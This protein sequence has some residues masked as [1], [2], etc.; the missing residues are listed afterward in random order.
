MS[1]SMQAKIKERIDYE[2]QCGV[3][4]T[5]HQGCLVQS[6]GTSY[7]AWLVD[8]YWDTL[9][10]S[11]AFYNLRKGVYNNKDLLGANRLCE[12]LHSNPTL[13]EIEVTKRM[14]KGKELFKE[15]LPDLPLGPQ[16]A[17]AYGKRLPVA[18]LGVI[19]R[20]VSPVESRIWP[21]SQS[22]APIVSPKEI[23][24]KTTPSGMDSVPDY[25]KIE[26]LS[27]VVDSDEGKLVAKT[28]EFFRR[29]EL[30]QKRAVV[31]SDEQQSVMFSHLFNDCVLI[32]D[33][34]PGTGKTSTM[35]QRLKLLISED[36]YTDNDYSQDDFTDGTD[37]QKLRTIWNSFLK[38][39]PDNQK[40]AFFSPTI[41]LQN[42]L[43]KNL[44]AEG[45]PDPVNSIK[46]WNE[47]DAPG[48]SYAFQIARDEYHFVNTIMKVGGKLIRKPVNNFFKSNPKTVYATFEELLLANLTAKYKEKFQLVAQKINGLTNEK[49]K[50][51]SSVLPKTDSIE[52]YFRTIERLSRAQAAETLEEIWHD[53][54]GV[55][56]ESS[57]LL[58]DFAKKNA[59]EIVQHFKSLKGKDDISLFYKWSMLIYILDKTQGAV[60]RNASRRTKRREKE[61]GIDSM[62]SA[63]T[64][65]GLFKFAMG[66][67][68]PEKNLRGFAYSD[69]LVDVNFV[70]QFS[71]VKSILSTKQEEA[72]VRYNEI[73]P[74]YQK[75][76][77]EHKEIQAL[78]NGGGAYSRSEYDRIELEY[79]EIQKKYQDAKEE[80][81]RIERW[82]ALDYSTADEWIDEYENFTFD[83]VRAIAE[84]YVRKPVKGMESALKNFDLYNKAKELFAD[85]RDLQSELDKVDC[86]NDL[87]DFLAYDLKSVYEQEFRGTQGFNSISDGIAIL[88]PQEH[89]FLIYAGNKI[90][91]KLYRINEERFNREYINQQKKAENAA[92]ADKGP[93]GYTIVLGYKN[94]WKVVIG[95]DESTDFT[96]MELAAIASLGHPKY[97]SVTL[98]G[99]QMQAFND[100]GIT[101]WKML[102]DGIFDCKHEVKKLSVSYR[103]SPTLLEMAKKI[104]KR[105]MHEEAPYRSKI[106]GVDYL[107]PQPLLFKSDDSE[108]CAGWIAQKILDIQN[109]EASLPAIAIF[110]PTSKKSEI[111]SFRDTMNEFLEN[112]CKVVS[113]YENDPNAKV[114]VYPISLVKGLEFEAAFFF[115]LDQLNDEHLLEQYLYVGLSRATYYLGATSSEDWIAPLTEDFMTD[116]ENSNWPKSL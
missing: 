101:E 104:Y 83:I 1:E 57:G 40:W 36:F 92:S 100:H 27:E 41:Q 74:I 39:F 37:L 70:N 113:C 69:D 35:I 3:K 64:F 14:K 94:S 19:N 115:N 34:G 32:I 17:K 22:D 54:I 23:P 108:E 25:E 50:P 45:L 16:V 76:K 47:K 2:D 15:I 96:P 46:V 43:S 112:V 24:V 68:F 12:G 79:P 28:N 62:S 89:S 33:G 81:E 7:W 21:S 13:L 105:N 4:K 53:A 110:C 38:S 51:L 106:D 9:F 99:D 11:N 114:V 20:N 71:N 73:E 103:Q 63:L 42:F 87:S 91:K 59:D 26:E 8:E 31:L 95:I 66:E 97:N 77:A 49:I 5:A 6:K 29:R 61:N 30:S 107:E 65:Y 55:D 44:S 52:N 48:K 18:A 80:K 67:I 72:L 84:E 86:E 10:R 116:E 75:I 78:V 111:E 102:D 109:A 82:I 58:Y 90:A 60:Y 88:Q 93:I 85:Y 98:V 56:N